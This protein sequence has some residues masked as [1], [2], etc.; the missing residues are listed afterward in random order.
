M[1]EGARP[2]IEALDAARHNR[3]AFRCG[4]PV[5]DHYLRS[6][7]SQDAKRRVAAPYVIV[8]PPSSDLLGYYTLSNA[9]VRTA[10]LPSDMVKR[11]P[12]YPVL[13]AT[14]L[15][16]LAVHETIRGQGFGGLLLLDAFRRALR[17]ETASMAIVVDAQD[18]TAAAFYQRHD[19]LPLADQ[20]R[21]LFLPMATVAKLFG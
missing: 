16:R 4:V 8:A 2:V 21:R 1:G 12:R 15:G 13:P 19:F 6:Q 18:G 5:L 3:G 20:P 11:L 17:S 14:L 7:A 9:V 10:E